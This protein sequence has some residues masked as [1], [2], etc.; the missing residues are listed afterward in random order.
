MNPNLVTLQVD[1][2]ALATALAAALVAQG[3]GGNTVDPTSL[4]D[5]GGCAPPVGVDV[6]N[7]D[8][9]DSAP[10]EGAATGALDADGLPW[11]ARIHSSSK[12]QT[13]KGVWTKRRGVDDATVTKVTAELK[14]A[15]NP[16]PPLPG[17]VP[18]AAPA[19]PAAPTPPTPPAPVAPPAYTELV[20]FVAA[21]SYDAES[22]PTGRIT[23]E[24]LKSVLDY[25]Q[26]PGSELQNL[27]HNPTLAKSV[28]D[29]MVTALA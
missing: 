29:Y 10:I 7:T 3:F 13:A 20:K 15:V 4:V 25:Y 17:M 11:D 6:S 27:A 2:T 19:T 1:V 26:V 16:V 21:N 12:T 18:P 24:W 8:D 9:N 28:H 22:N 14:A 5:A 23:T